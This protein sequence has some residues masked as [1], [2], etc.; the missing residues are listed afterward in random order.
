MENIA[1]MLDDVEKFPI[2]INNQSSHTFRFHS[3]VCPYLDGD[4][5][6]SLAPG[7]TETTNWAFKNPINPLGEVDVT[8]RWG[9]G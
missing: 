4:G 9:E 2:T 7:E 1:E 3:I 8:V 5:G 6:L